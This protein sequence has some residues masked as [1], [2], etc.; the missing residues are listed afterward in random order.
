MTAAQKIESLDRFYSD[1]PN[2][3]YCTDHLG[4]L[5]VRPKAQAAKKKYI[6][7]NQPCL[8]SY[9]VFDVDR[10]DAT[11]AWF[12]AN[13]PMPYWTSQNPENGHCHI[14]YRLTIPFPTSDIAHLK[15]IRYAA[16]V[17]AALAEQ[18]GADGGYS[19]LITKNPL[20]PHW[21][22][23]VWTEDTYE[24]GYLADFVEIKGFPK[25]QHL[26]Q[27]LGRNC[28]V[29]DTAR[30]WA[31][32]EIR[33]YW[34]S[35]YTQWQQAVL[36]HCQNINNGFTEPL[37][38]NE[39]KATAKSISKWTWKNI[40]KSKFNSVQALRG[41][42]GGLIGNSS[43]GGKARSKRY[44]T[45]RLQAILLRKQGLSYSELAKALNISRKTAINWCSQVV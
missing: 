45:L 5:Y 8:I 15:P 17:Q 41:R 42:K 39:I 13:L 9:F 16:A 23:V 25:K 19:G 37:D 24:L 43:N 10:P 12:D 6:Q 36:A 1:L 33:N 3:P 35:G 38:H 7:H 21:R 40:T 26:D 4:T 34:D 30:K 29:F 31:Y 18:L 14:C 2:K 22:T 32:S 28:H 20:H 11:L 27:G 44:D